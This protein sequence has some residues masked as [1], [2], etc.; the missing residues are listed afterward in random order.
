MREPLFHV[1]LTQKNMFFM[2][3]LLYAFISFLFRW[4]NQWNGETNI[5]IVNTINVQ[6]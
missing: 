5:V 6:N 3:D 1:Y 4:N 2:T